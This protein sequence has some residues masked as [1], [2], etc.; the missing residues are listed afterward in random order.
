[1]EVIAL[2]GDITD[3]YYYYFFVLHLRTKL[4]VRLPSL[5]EDM[6]HF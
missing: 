2:V 6:T 4:E 1:L 5:A 3:Y